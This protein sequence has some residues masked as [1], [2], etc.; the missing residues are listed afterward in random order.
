LYVWRHQEQLV[1]PPMQ[2]RTHVLWPSE[3]AIL[4]ASVPELRPVPVRALGDAPQVE[5]VDLTSLIQTSL[6]A[7]AVELGSASA[8]TKAGVRVS[9]QLQAFVRRV[10][11]AMAGETVLLAYGRKV[12]H[13][14]ESARVLPGVTLV[15]ELLGAEMDALRGEAPLL[16]ALADRCREAGERVMPML[17][18]QGMAHASPWEVPLVKA[19]A[20]QL[21]GAGLGLRYR[22]DDDGPRLAWEE[23]PLLGLVVGRAGA[24]P[25]TLLMALERCREV[26]GIV[27]EDPRQAWPGWASREPGPGPWVLTVEGRGLVA[28]VIGKDV[29]WDMPTLPEMHARPGRSVALLA[30]EEAARLSEKPD[31][32]ARR[33]ALLAHLLAVRAGGGGDEALAEMP[34]LRR[35]D[36]RALTPVRNVS[37]THAQAESPRA[38]Q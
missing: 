12:A 36:P 32:D 25:V 35:F 9:L 5:R 37:M 34:L 30:A 7:V 38:R 22:D 19:R 31:E 21:S 1:P 3:L 16:Q 10:P 29:L 26:G 6:P 23:S 27:V 17:L 13:V 4:R 14:R 11:T 33:A 2:P 20:E 28:R 15:C 8:T 24:E 18:A